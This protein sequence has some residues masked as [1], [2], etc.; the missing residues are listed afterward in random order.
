M[1]FY[2]KKAKSMGVPIVPMIDILTILLIFFIVHT[3][4]K[5]PQSLLKIDVPG[6]E[7]MKGT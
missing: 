5:K 3:Q 7:F 6:A 2:R 1:Q 4:W